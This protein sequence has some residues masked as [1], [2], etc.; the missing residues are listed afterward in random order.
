MSQV[1]NFDAVPGALWRAIGSEIGLVLRRR[2]NQVLLAGLA[3]LPI[4]IGL[5]VKLVSSHTDGGV[6]LITK[7]TNSGLFLAAVVFVVSMPLFLPLVISVVAGDALAAETQLGTTRYA[8]ILPVSRTKWLGMKAVGLVVFVIAGV[9]TVLVVSL[10]VGFALFG[11]SDMTLLSGD[12]IGP[13]A[14][15][16]RIALMSVYVVASEMGMVAVGLFISSLTDV[17]IV[18]MAGTAIVPAVCTVL[19]A[20]PQ[21]QAIQPGLLTYHWLDLTTFLFAQPDVALI[22]QGLLV[23]LAWVAVFGSLA[24]ARVASTDVKA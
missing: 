11:V 23:Q 17:P 8:M 22:R 24:W 2:R 21:L 20:V 9:A 13:W 18:A 5:A 16:G 6:G 15:V 1:E 3:A 19:L 14:G 7:I 12:T 10:V 4:V